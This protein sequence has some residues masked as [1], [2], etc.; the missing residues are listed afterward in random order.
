[1]ANK[2]GYHLIH[3][4]NDE[5]VMAGQGTQALELLDQV[6]DIDAVLVAVGGGGLISGISTAFKS[7]SP[8]IEVI[9]VEPDVAN[10]AQQSLGAGERV[11]LK[12]APNTVADAVRTM[13]VGDKTFP[14]LQKQENDTFNLGPRSDPS[15][16]REDIRVAGCRSKSP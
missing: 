13:I 12:S 9:G 3:P 16:D 4:F 7:L 10:D 11:S 14:H 1:M 6:K 2:T 5:R 15:Y 8:S